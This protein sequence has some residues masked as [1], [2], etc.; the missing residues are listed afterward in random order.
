MASD[1]KWYPPQ[2]AP[3]P[4]P[5]PGAVYQPRAAPAP[6]P[7]PAPIVPNKS[8][9]GCLV[10]ALIVLVLFGIAAV[11]A[12]ATIAYFG[13]KA[14][15]KLEELEDLGQENTVDPDD[16]GGR[17]EDQVVGFGDSVELSGYTTTVDNAGFEE[18]L[19]ELESAGYLVADV[20]IV[21]RD[22]EPQPFSIGDWTVQTPDGQLIPATLT[23]GADDRLVGG[24]LTAKGRVE[25]RITFEIGTD[26][27]GDYFVIYKP[28][29]FDAARGIWKVEL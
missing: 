4:P 7:A 11:G 19:S 10:V 25:G 18:S 20:T 21:N 3:P 26:A 16:V 5:P 15:N 2:S 9:K 13:N 1:G 8:G 12:V 29:P 14:E 28:D 23:S 24:M 27:G 6:A 22:A 17:D